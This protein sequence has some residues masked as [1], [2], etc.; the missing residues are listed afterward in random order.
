MR[1]SLAKKNDVFIP[2]NSNNNS[3]IHAHTPFNLLFFHLFH[4]LPLLF[5]VQCTL[6]FTN[7][8]YVSH[9]FLLGTFAF[10]MNEANTNSRKE[11]RA[12]KNASIRKPIFNLKQ[13][14][15]DCNNFKRQKNQPKETRPKR[16]VKLLSYFQSD[17]ICLCHFDTQ[18]YLKFEIHK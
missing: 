5:N 15:R 6:T 16:V 11:E 2:L 10:P 13:P 9:I 12:T 14:K 3:N 1:W 8:I 4:N 18:W 17:T 7:V